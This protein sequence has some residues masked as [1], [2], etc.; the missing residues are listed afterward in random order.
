MFFG[1]LLTP[2]SG[3]FY[4]VLGYYGRTSTPYPIDAEPKEI[5]TQ[6]LSFLGQKILD[7]TVDFHIQLDKKCFIDSVSLQFAGKPQGLGIQIL[8]V[9]ERG[10]KLL[11]RAC[12]EG[13]GFS[14][15]Q[16]TLFSVNT[17][18]KHLILRVDANY[19]NF[20]MGHLSLLGAVEVDKMVYPIPKHFVRRDGLLISPFVVTAD[21]ECTTAMRTFIEKCREM[22]SFSIEEGVC[23]N[24]CMQVS[25]ALEKEAFSI[26][27]T[28][29]KAELKAGSGRAMLYAVEKLLQLCGLNGIDC[30]CLEDAPAFPIRGI[31]IGLPSPE[32]MPLIHR[33][34]KYVWVPMGYNTLF[35]EV[36]GAM[37]Y[38]SHP[39]I[40]ETWERLCRLYEQGEVPTPAHYGMLPH[41][42]VSIEDVRRF[43]SD[44]RACGMEVI[45]EV[46]TLG[47]TQYITT[48]YP[49]LAEIEDVAD[50]GSGDRFYDDARP[51]VVYYHCM[52]PNHP[53]YYKVIFD[54]MDDVIEAFQPKEYVHIGHDEIYQIGKCKICKNQNPA[55]IYAKEVTALHDHL[56]Q[57]GLKT[58]MWSDMMEETKRYATVDAVY[59][60]PKD[61]V[62]LS[63]TWY[64]HLDETLD[65]E[66]RLTENG[67][68][69]MIGNL[70][71]SHYSRFEARTANALCLGGE[72]STWVE[73][74][75]QVLGY[76]GKIYDFLYTANMLWAAGDQRLRGLYNRLIVQRMD[77]VR[78]RIH[79]GGLPKKQKR[80]EIALDGSSDAVPFDIAH[81]FDSALKVQNGEVNIPINRKVANLYL[82]QATDL[83]DR[84]AP[85]Q[86]MKA[87]G[88]Y[89]IHYA[90]GRKHQEPIY[91][92]YGLGNYRRCFASPLSSSLYRHEGYISTYPAL[93]V[94]KKNLLGEDVT[95]Y[96]YQLRNPYPECEVV[97]L[98]VSYD[99]P[100]KVSLLLFG[101]EAEEI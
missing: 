39:K 34:V 15:E 6:M 43:C 57:K 85:W 87:L 51:S 31:H 78:C 23:G 25:S 24:I 99:S 10:E 19:N 17:E 11:H 9:T 64:F 95:L 1:D 59:S 70:Y 38:P 32:Q 28:P 36:A 65:I 96:E 101:V 7:D 91:Y 71:S 89:T 74:S 47:H 33:L 63:F 83:P 81:L 22:Y 30:C 77:T 61:V 16:E 79:D 69:Y 80:E 46:Q 35:V 50:E 41:T 2:Q 98:S 52:C 56:A 75:E 8:S 29:T 40:N 88:G 62:C 26:F 90:D 73:N 86:K 3:V 4:Q 14:V 49:H 5:C 94:Q 67:L 82:L 18:A 45:P 12:G 72:L 37:E 68:H 66:K 44:C 84:R 48:A 55:E 76:E 92:G 13:N 21:E 100:R 20:S 53:D 60:I 42:T 58:M 93:P 97:S 54:V 27:V